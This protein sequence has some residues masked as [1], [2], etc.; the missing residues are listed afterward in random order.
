MNCGDGDVV[1]TVAYCKTTMEEGIFREFKS[2]IDWPWVTV[3]G[4]ICRDDL[5]FEIE[6]AAMPQAKRQ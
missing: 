6:A 4:D 1:Q 3:I 5:L 2:R